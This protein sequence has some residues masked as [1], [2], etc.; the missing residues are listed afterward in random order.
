MP[1]FAVFAMGGPGVET[2]RVGALVGSALFAPRVYAYPP[3]QQAARGEDKEGLNVRPGLTG[4]C[5]RGPRNRH[6]YFSGDAFSALSV[7]ASKS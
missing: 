7:S 5:R 6:G 3:P 2:Q 1:P 4:R